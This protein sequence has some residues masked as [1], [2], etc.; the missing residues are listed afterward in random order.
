MRWEKYTTYCKARVYGS[1]SDA[2]NNGDCS[3]QLV[4]NTSNGYYADAVAKKVKHKITVQTKTK[5]GWVK[6][7]SYG[8]GRISNTKALTW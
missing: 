8:A 3:K 5:S 1:I 7:Y 4:F 2:T 6:G